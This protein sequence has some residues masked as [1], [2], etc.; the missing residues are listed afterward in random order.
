MLFVK[1]TCAEN[2]NEASYKSTDGTSGWVQIL[3][4]NLALRQF[5]P[6]CKV[7][8]RANLL[9]GGEQRGG[10]G[11][12]NLEGVQHLRHLGCTALH[13]CNSNKYILQLRQI[14][15]TIWTNTVCNVEKYNY[16]GECNMFLHSRQQCS[17]KCCS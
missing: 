2:S 13:H 14:H 3:G 4:L 5:V 7:F 17:I 12:S 6:F 1:L 8:F 16:I 15:L 9:S 10:S 11:E